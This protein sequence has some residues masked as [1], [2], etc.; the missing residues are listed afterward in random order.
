M[1]S[2]KGLLGNSLRASPSP[3]K[4]CSSVKACS[5]LIT[6]ASVTLGSCWI[7]CSNC[8]VCWEVMSKSK[9]KEICAAFCQEPPNSLI[10]SSNKAKPVGR[11]SVIAMTKQVKKLPIGCL[12]KRL[13]LSAMLALWVINQAPRRC[14]KP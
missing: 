10:P 6:K 8:W 11:L 4:F 13:K 5:R 2:G 7:S 12:I 14:R 1:L 3:A 9:N